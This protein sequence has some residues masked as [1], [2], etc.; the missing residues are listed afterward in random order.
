[1]K[2]FVFVIASL[3]IFFSSC[4]VPNFSKDI[5][6]KVENGQSYSISEK[7]SIFFPKGLDA[8]GMRYFPALVGK[9]ENRGEV[10]AEFGLE[11]KFYQSKDYY[12]IRLN[13]GEG[14]DL[15]GQGMAVGDL[16]R[17]E[18]EIFLWNTDNFV[19]ARNGG[20]RLYQSH[21]WVM[22]VRADGSAFGFIAATTAKASITTFANTIVFT[23]KNFAFPAIIIEGENPEVVLGELAKL[24]GY[25]ELP[26]LW[27]LGYQQCRWSYYPDSRAKEV[28]DTF[29]EKEIPCDVIW[30]D[31]HYMDGYRVFT[32]DKKLFPDPAEMND[33]LHQRKFKSVWMIDPGVK[34]D[35]GYSVYDSGTQKDVWVKDKDGKDFTGTVWPGKCVFP[36]FT[37]AETQQWWADLYK[38]YM[39]TGIDGVWNDMNEPSVFNGPDVTMPDSN[40][41]RGGDEIPADIHENYH[42]IYG[43]LMVRSSKQGILAA[44]PEKR[45]F[46]L[47]RSNFLGGQRYAA[48]W[49]GDNQAS[50][51]HM[52]M[53][54]PMSLN[55]GLSGQPF[56]G[57]DIGGF[58]PNT[59]GD[60][61]ARWI[62]VGAFMP[63]S[64]GHAAQGTNDKEP[65]AFGEKVEDVAR[66]S[67]QRRYRALPYLYTLFQEASVTGLPVMRPV[68]FADF[69]DLSLRKEQSAFMWGRDLLIIPQLEKGKVTAH[70]LPR[71]LWQEISLIDGDNSC[72][73]FPVLMQRGGSIIPLTEVIQSTVDYN[74]DAA[75]ELSVV[76]E[77]GKAEGT[78]YEDAGD[79]FSYRKGE[80]RKIKFS[81]TFDETAKILTLK[82]SV[83]DGKWQL[84]SRK[85]KLTVYINGVKLSGQVDLGAE[86]KVELK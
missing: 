55:M 7:S 31:I 3:V 13:F 72:V 85:V 78:L 29:R 76:I 54:I 20:K 1:M 61:F 56:T 60:L 17:S 80:F 25:M 27:T 35:P 33:Y 12:E 16:E 9:I 43:F 79:G 46:I 4:V 48:M 11:P 45:P 10:G 15:Y 74:L 57:P 40:Y 14:V 66:V 53:S 49:T 5:L 24:T 50:W 75:L 23:G 18:K 42:N 62:G 38:D 83:I 65:W 34:H 2:K 37:M 44:N 71:G 6:V 68:F 64:R 63:F 41:H 32:F 58:S 28:A 39:A 70:N 69:T 26:A 82:S 8:A 51:K 36:D 73:D 59:S 30:F 86:S 22:G 52:Q 47:S 77:N 19:Y 21:P 81:A 67:I 84:P